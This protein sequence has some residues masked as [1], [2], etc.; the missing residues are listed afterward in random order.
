MKQSD[1]HDRRAA[2]G[3]TLCGFLAILLWGTSLALSRSLSEKIGA[4]TAVAAVYTTGGILGSLPLLLNRNG[5][6][7]FSSRRKIRPLPERCG[8]VTASTQRNTGFNLRY[9]LICGTLFVAYILLLFFALEGASNRA[10]AIQVGL[11]NY[12]WTSLTLL[13]SIPVLGQRARPWI[14]PGTLAALAGEYLVL[15][16]ESSCSPMAFLDALSSY[17]VP[18]ILS[19]L[20]AFAWAAYSTLAR[21]L[22]R[23]GD[24][25]LAP[26]FL[27]ATGLI[28]LV[29]RFAL[30]ETGT[31]SS[32]ALGE[33]AGLCL[34]TTLGYGLWDLAMR[35]GRLTLVAAASYATPLLSTLTMSWYLGV[36]PSLRLLA[37]TLLLV[38]GSLASWYAFLRP[39]QDRR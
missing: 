27:L 36:P 12:L 32:A 5:P 25:G 3:S 9:A 28:A 20:G 6:V 33:A 29:L 39:R 37:G 8:G 18:F 1:P 14:L 35:R 34:V 24:R 30:R 17:P 19:L 4:L 31:W 22:T 2:D 16:P 23:P 15:V 10:Q 13:L 11:I 38:V 7:R 21:R 26:L